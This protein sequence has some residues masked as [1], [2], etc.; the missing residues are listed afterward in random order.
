[1]IEL[2]KDSIKLFELINKKDVDCFYL[3]RKV[4]Q[5]KAKAKG[6]QKEVSKIIFK[7]GKT[8][9]DLGPNYKN[10]ILELREAELI[11]RNKHKSTE[12]F[13]TEKGLDYADTLEEKSF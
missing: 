8:Y 5:Y 6:K 3:E 11:T 12:F 7:V 1:M 10:I 4:H 9:L 2:S 13:I